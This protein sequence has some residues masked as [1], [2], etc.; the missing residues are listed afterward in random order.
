M[1]DYFRRRFAVSLLMRARRYSSAIVML[2][3]LCRY[4]PYAA[5][6]LIMS[7]CRFRHAIAMPI[8]SF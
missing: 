7:R 5:R 8:V 2:A 6:C 3:M 4:A 1:F